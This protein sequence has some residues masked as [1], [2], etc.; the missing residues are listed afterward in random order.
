MNLSFSTLACENWT[1]QEICLKAKQY[2]YQGV[3]LRFT[4]GHKDLPTNPE[5]TPDV[6][7]QA[8]MFAEDVGVKIVCV[9][10]SVHLTHPNQLAHGKKC[11]EIAHQLGSHLLRVFA[12][13]HPAQQ[14]REQSLS[15]AAEQAHELAEFGDDLDVK[16]LLET[17]D[18]CI[19][20]DDV[21]EMVQRVDHANFGIL[22]DSHHTYR[23]GG[24]PFQTTWAKIGHLVEHIHVK[25][26]IGNAAKH[27]YKL[28]S[29]G[30]IPLNELFRLL[31]KFGYK[32]TISVEWE[33]AWIP[34]LEAPEIALPEWSLYLRPLIQ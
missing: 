14:T 4:A 19:V 11:I 1:W 15:L 18:S 31:K 27:E 8:R 13:G 12:G 33:R 7:K 22:W 2:G 5:F 29:K 23:I 16:V 30:N 9:D 17:H 26:S 32:K 34:S 28:P 25:D 10:S 3:E 6:V 20:S 24:E 21:L